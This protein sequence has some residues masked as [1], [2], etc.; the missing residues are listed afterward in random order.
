MNSLLLAAICIALF[1]LS[2]V[3]YASFLSRKIFGLNADSRTPA[4]TLEDGVDY[5]PTRRGVLFGHHFA[6][7]AGLG[8]ILGPAIGVIWGWLPAVL[9]VVF[10]TIF[11]GAVHDL[12]ALVVSMRNEGRSIGDVTNRIIGPRGRILFMIIIFFLV[13]LAMG[14][15]ALVIAKL[16]VDL[17]PEAIVPVF[18]LMVI[19]VGIGFIA[20][21]LKVN[22]VISTLLG[23]GLMLA[24]IYV[25]V[26]YP[27]SL[28]S[29]FL[30]E[31][32]SAQLAE[33][34]PNKRLGANVLV[35]H[36]GDSALAPMTVYARADVVSQADQ[37][38]QK[39]GR[40][41]VYQVLSV[42]K[43]AG[44]A[45]AAH[46]E[47]SGPAGYGI[48]VSD[49]ALAKHL[50]DAKLI[51]DAAG[52]TE[53]L[54]QQARQSIVAGAVNSDFASAARSAKK[55]LILVLLCY[56]FVASVLPVWLLLQPRDYLN[57]YKLYLGMGLMIVGLI[58]FHP[59]IAAPAINADLNAAGGFFKGLQAFLFSGSKTLPAVFPLMFMIIA[60]GAVSG[61]HSLVSSGTTAKQISNEKHARMIGYGGM[62]FEGVLAIIVIVA[63]TAGVAYVV[64][65]G[66]KTPAERWAER[67]SGFAA[68]GTL[69][70]QLDAV[71]NGGGLLISKAGLP[72]SFSAAFVAAVAVAFAMTTLDTGTRL[73]RYNIEEFGSVLK[74][75]PLTNRYIASIVAVGAL[76]FFALRP[77]QAL[78]LW[79]LFGASNQLLAVL[80]LLIA[81]IYIYK[82]GKSV[83]YTLVPMMFLA[84]ATVVAMV[85]KIRSFWPDAEG[86]GDV[87]LLAV[88]VIVMAMAAW[89]AVEGVMAVRSHARKRTAIEPA[90]SAT[91]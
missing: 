82:L 53:E 24:A 62:V 36:A 78:G 46:I 69:D 47:R 65:T 56:A 54:K 63:C 11:I 4:H 1:A 16:F 74:I 31:S 10:G 50:I 88:S 18:S 22:M 32:R 75:R 6:S 68:M 5:V 3:F 43:A 70:P 33:I 2:Y 61:F 17:H 79:T 57:S 20:Y 89:L 72:F 66:D 60:C 90:D 14:V 8:P 45:L 27:V 41:P 84:I 52:A 39:G 67:Y 71:I 85:H 87:G 64:T 86:K 77:E 48:D 51:E 21:K 15:F 28:F 7:I 76:A 23:V 26:L 80:G 73:L 29:I 13:A 55:A 35:T 12:A 19:A 38:Y 91:S 37:I 25:G 59:Q 40:Q 58:V 81:T 42:W 83:I 9:W 44:A 30:P 49:E 34:C